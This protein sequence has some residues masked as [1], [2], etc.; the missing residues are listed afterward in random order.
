MFVE[1]V[2]YFQQT[3]GH[4]TASKY[5]KSGQSGIIHRKIAGQSGSIPIA[6]PNI[7]TIKVVE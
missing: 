4:A 6:T 7:Q 5:P 1:F 3:I 2:S